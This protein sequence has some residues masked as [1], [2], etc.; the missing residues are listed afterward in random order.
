MQLEPNCPASQMEN[1]NVARSQTH[2][3]K[4]IPSLCRVSVCCLS[5]F[6]KIMHIIVNQSV[7]QSK[8][9]KPRRANEGEHS[10]GPGQPLLLRQWKILFSLALLLP[11]LCFACAVLCVSACAMFIV[12]YS[13][14]SSPWL[15]VRGRLIEAGYKGCTCF[16]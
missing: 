15:T 5:L 13:R 8:I 10:T 2:T 11:L 6:A 16:F 9:A 7:R 1:V 3:Q 4:F 14:C 12:T